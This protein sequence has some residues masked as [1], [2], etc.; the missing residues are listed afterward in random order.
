MARDFGWI[1][2]ATLGKVHY[3]A[4]RAPDNV[5]GSVPKAV[6]LGTVPSDVFD[7]GMAPSCVSEALSM[8]VRTVSRR[9]DYPDDPPSRMDLHY[10]SRERE[11]STGVQRGCLIASGVDALRD[12]WM[13]ETSWPHETS[14]SSRWTTKPPALSHDAPR[15]VNAEAL[16][17]NIPDV[18]YEI[19]AGSVVVLGCLIGESWETFSGDY[20]P[21]PQGPALAGHAFA[22]VGYDLPMQCLRIRNSWGRGFGDGGEAWLPW[23][24]VTLGICGEA[25]AIRNVRRAR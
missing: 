20:I 22:V 7:Q 3:G 11:G 10:R 25:F 21:E 9:D 17:I 16:A 12:G 14:W 15:L 19:A 23:E 24:Y 13:N 4:S 6:R 2:P 1:H 5:F 18:V 8:A